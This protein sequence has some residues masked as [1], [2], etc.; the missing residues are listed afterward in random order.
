MPGKTTLRYILVGY[1]K[2][3]LNESNLEK[4]TKDLDKEDVDKVNRASK[5]F[6][7]YIENI[8]SQP[9]YKK[10]I[11]Q[12]E[13]SFWTGIHYEDPK[14]Q[15]KRLKASENYKEINLKS[16]NEILSVRIN[17]ALRAARINTLGEL[18]EKGRSNMKKVRQIGKGSQKEL[19]RI[20]YELV[21][22]EEYKNYMNK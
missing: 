16:L 10:I 7:E 9:K 17:N 11:T 12:G 4:L 20:I 3:K 18:V 2:A 21:P 14:E 22:R 19:E 15:I 6:L 5:E 1:G 8:Y 13:I